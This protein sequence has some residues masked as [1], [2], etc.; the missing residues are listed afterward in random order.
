MNIKDL[1]DNAIYDSI[2]FYK[3]GHVAP[4]IPAL[5]KVNPNQLGITY[6]DLKSNAVYSSRDV[7]KRFAIE[8][9]SKVISISTRNSRIE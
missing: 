3:N 6:Y 8:N 7:D 4:Y 1:L 5:G 2:N 9:I